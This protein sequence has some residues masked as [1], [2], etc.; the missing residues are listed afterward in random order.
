MGVGETS[1]GVEGEGV[2]GGDSLESDAGP[3]FD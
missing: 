2:A 1:G 3:P